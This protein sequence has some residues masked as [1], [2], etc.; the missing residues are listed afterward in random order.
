MS[1]ATSVLRVATAG[2][3]AAALVLAPAGSAVA[4]KP[5]SAPPDNGRHGLRTL[6]VEPPAALRLGRA[7][8]LTAV[9]EYANGRRAEV[10]PAWSSSDTGVV[11]V[12]AAGV[13][14]AVRSGTATVT[15]VL[16]RQTT[17]VQVTVAPPTVDFGRVVHDRRGGRAIALV[18]A[19]FTPGSVVTLTGYG[20]TDRFGVDRDGAATGGF[21]EVQPGPGPGTVL[22]PDGATISLSPG[23]CF[24]SDGVVPVTA[25]DV[26]GT[27]VTAHYRC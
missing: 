15:A 21:R 7:T 10:D 25:T 4:A 23:A 11:T 13:V 26:S 19:G 17:S 2:A 24:G 9:G 12:D 1:L 16:H 20:Q 18:L 22:V 8:D 6:T 27:A 5:A 3:A 14:R